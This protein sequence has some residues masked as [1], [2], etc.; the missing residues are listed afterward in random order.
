MLPQVMR[1]G[2]LDIHV[3]VSDRRRSIQLTIE[4]DATVTAVIPP[5]TDEAKLAK[6]IT[7]KRPWLYA[8]LRERA[9]LGE[10]RAPREYV[11]GEGFPY[12]GRS[13]RLLI[14]EEAP[15]PVRLNRGRLE[16]RR[17]SVEDA[18]RQ[19]T[20]WYRQ[21]GEPWLR[22]RIPLWAARLGVEVTALRVLPLG[23]RWASCTQ[24]GKV[25]IHWA[26]MQLPPDLIDYVLVHELAHLR[27]PD[28]GPEFWRIVDRAMPDYSDR[29]DRLRRLGPDLW[30]PEAQPVPRQPRVPGAEPS[31]RL[32]S[33]QSG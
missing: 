16:L 6:V 32:N 9:S 28:H 12:L 2:D 11:T 30:L 17:D 3:R 23:Y 18:A 25:N 22:R 1:V 7:A 20:R 29:R 4:R 10:P 31:V 14:V 15:R 19:V 26:T 5:A 13:Y 33:R 24:D 27:R 21:V 8:K